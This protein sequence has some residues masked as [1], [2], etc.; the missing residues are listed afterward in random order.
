MHILIIKKK[1]KKPSNDGIRAGRAK[2]FFPHFS[3]LN[4]RYFEMPSYR[5]SW[6]VAAGSALPSEASRARVA[7]VR[8]SGPQIPTGV[9]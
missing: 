1:K 6:S 7:R 9:R 3:S 2:N 5:Q 8:P 4:I